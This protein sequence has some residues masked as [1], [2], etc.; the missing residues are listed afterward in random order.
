MTTAVCLLV[1]VAACSSSNERSAS[2]SATGAS[3]TASSA[4]DSSASTGTAPIAAG[5]TVPTPDPARYK[6]P[7]CSVSDAQAAVPETTPVDQKGNADLTSFDG[8]RIRI[9]WFPRPGVAAGAQVPTVL[10]GPGWGMGGDTDTGQTDPNGGLLSVFGVN[11]PTLWQQGYNVLTWDPRGFGESGGTVEVDAAQYEGRDVQRL[12]SWVAVQPQAE[13]DGPGDPRVGMVGGSYGGGIQLVTAAIDCRVDVIVPEIA[14][15]S[16]VSSLYKADTVKVGWAGLLYGIAANRQLDPHI[17]ASYEEGISGGRLSPDNVAFYADRGVQDLVTKIRVPTLLLQ[18]TVDTLFTLDEA[19]RNLAAISQ[20]APTAMV[21]FCGGHGFCLTDE[22]DKGRVTTA[23][24]AW[25]Q[26]YLKREASAPTLPTFDTIDQDGKRFTAT[27]YPL[28][29]GQPITASGSGSLPMQAQGGSG[30][31]TPPPGTG[32]ILTAVAAGITPAKAT[33]AVDVTV[34]W[35]DRDAL[36]VG[37]PSLRLSYTG[38]AGTGDKPQRVFAQLVDD[39]TGLVLGNQVTPIQVVL[40]GK[41]HT[42]DVPLEMVSFSARPGATLT[43]QIV[44]TTV[45]YA[46]PQ[47]GG[48]VTFDKVDIELP[49]VTAVP[50]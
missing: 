45:A 25:L 8:T 32:G 13:L 16:L 5:S 38:T 17:K 36:V 34:T 42:A 21:W 39:T 28:P 22:G 6:P 44:A 35:A 37:A 47:Q 50:S 1:A 33:S 19:V 41:P 30:P 26:R 11:I 40:D 49:T 7:T 18:G 4:T 43:L 2:S 14:W 46:Q 15:S 12:L 10:M 20:H 27:T 3:G 31:A 48:S 24:F 23:T 29:A 9:H